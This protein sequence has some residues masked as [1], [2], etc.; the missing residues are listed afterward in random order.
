MG[1]EALARWELPDGTV[2]EASEFIGELIEEGRGPDLARIVVDQAAAE[3]SAWVKAEPGLGQFVAVN[4]AA[5][6]M[7][8]EEVAEIIGS[9]VRRH[10]LP[11]GAL[12]V[13]ITEDRI[14]A[15]QSR[16]LAAAKAIRQAGAS[17]AVDDFGVGYSTLGRL[18]KFRFDIVKLDR[19]LIEGLSSS[20]KQRS[21]IR[22]MLSAA[23]KAGAPV[24]AEGIEDEATA[25]VLVELGCDFGQGFLFGKAEKVG[26]N[27]VPT[28]PQQPQADA[29]AGAPPVRGQPRPGDLR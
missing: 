4:I 17:L 20:K 26:G 21:V 10:D 2:R 8:K 15:S 14:Q 1:F 13:E 16:A 5:A 19:S 3:L 11:A 28:Q 6:D 9:A 18:S 27:E 24:V 25:E 7:P 12:V 22:A 23:E 29:S